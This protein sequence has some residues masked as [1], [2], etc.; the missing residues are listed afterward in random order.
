MLEFHKLQEVW[1]KEEQKSPRQEKVAEPVT[2]LTGWMD[3]SSKQG[4]EA[5]EWHRS[6]GQK[7]RHW[8]CIF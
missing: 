1:R 4:Q 5:S 6:D 7:G 8:D 2:F 3:Y